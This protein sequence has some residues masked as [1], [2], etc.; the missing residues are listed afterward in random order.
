MSGTKVKLLKLSGYYIN[1]RFDVIISVLC[2]HT[3]PVPKIISVYTIHRR[4]FIIE[5]R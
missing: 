2:P 1:R 3:M 5:V 4:I